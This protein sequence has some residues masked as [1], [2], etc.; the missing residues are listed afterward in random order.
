M[1]ATETLEELVLVEAGFFSG[2]L[3]KLRTDAGM[4]QAELAEKADIDQ[5]AISLLER[6]VHNPTWNTVI[7]FCIIFGV[8]CEAFRPPIA[9]PE[10]P[11]ASPPTRRKRSPRKDADA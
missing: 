9:P 3:K 8:S 5:T 4:T 1:V 7:K 2:V 10:S 11:A 6:G